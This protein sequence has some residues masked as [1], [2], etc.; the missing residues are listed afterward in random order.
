MTTPRDPAPDTTTLD[1]IRHV[2][3]LAEW[4][5]DSAA[6]P[7][8][9]DVIHDTSY[10]PNLVTVQRDAAT[11]GNPRV[12]TDSGD[13][14]YRSDVTHL[15]PRPIHHGPSMAFFPVFW[16]VTGYVD[17]DGRTARVH[18]VY[19]VERDTPDSARVRFYEQHTGALR[20]VQCKPL[21]DLDRYA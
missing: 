5:R 9:P 14:Q 7:D 4:A 11:S 2:E 1:A 10:Q 6:V 3:N 21:Y 17:V 18:E 12:T 16:L 19:D 8:N 20:D 13:V 15:E